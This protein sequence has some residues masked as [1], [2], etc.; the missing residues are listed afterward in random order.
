M[1]AHGNAVRAMTWSHN[2]A[3][4][5]SGDHKGI[6]Q[7]YQKNLRSLQQYVIHD[8]PVR[9]LRCAPSAPPSVLHLL[10][11]CRRRWMIIVCC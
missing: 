10:P 11:L 4:L 8:E 1:Q 6:V 7:Y 3:F 2:G 5:I 9:G